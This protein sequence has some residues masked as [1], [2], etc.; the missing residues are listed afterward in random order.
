MFWINILVSLYLINFPI[1]YGP[2][3][4]KKMGSLYLSSV[5]FDTDSYIIPDTYFLG[6]NI[7]LFVLIPFLIHNLIWIIPLTNSICIILYIRF[8][9]IIMVFIFVFFMLSNSIFK[10][11]I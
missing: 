10:K 2:L 7:I 6:G 11:S 4:Y 8:N 9:T 3:S 1:I 5:V